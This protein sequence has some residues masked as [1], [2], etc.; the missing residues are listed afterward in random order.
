[1]AR[2]LILLI[3]L[4]LAITSCDYLDFKGMLLTYTDVDTRFES[5]I[6]WNDEH[7]SRDFDINSD[8][9]TFFIMSDS[10]LGGTMNITTMYNEATSANADA[11]LMIGDLCSGNQEDY[12][13]LNAV[14]ERYPNIPALQVVGNHDLYFEGWEYYYKYFG[15][16][17]YY[18]TVNTLSASDLF[19]ML[20]TGGGTLGDLQL[21]WLKDLLETQRDN[22]RNCI[23]L[24]HNN[25][26]KS[27][28]T[29]ST[30]PMQ[31]EIKVLLDLFLIYDVDYCITGHDH[32]YD[33]FTFGSTHYIVTDALL[34]SYEDAAYL[35]L[36]VQDGTISVSHH[37][38]SE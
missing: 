30:L 20:D 7:D 8:D 23:I 2:Q 22:F 37:P 35:Q 33:T 12:D 9:Y 17:T 6:A 4:S 26:I 19:I 11:V 16:S 25:L 18:F 29:I 21:D 3:I 28:T 13:T 14:I 36:K 24:T 15:T 5:S 32:Q 31:E 38:V 10:H 34:D 1:M 27:R